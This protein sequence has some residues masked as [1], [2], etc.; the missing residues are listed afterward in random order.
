MPSAGD[1][2][3]KDPKILGGTPVFRGTRVPLQALFDSLEGGETLEEFLEGFP[4][5]SREMA[6][7]ALEEAQQ[8]LSSKA[9]MRIL[10]D[11]CVNQRLRNYLPGH[12][13]RSARYAGL[14]GL[15]NGELLKEAE[16]AKFDVLIT[17]DRGF[18][19]E[20]NLSG[21]KIAVII[22]HAKSIGLKDLLPLIGDCLSQLKSI[23]PGQVLRIG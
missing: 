16:A 11:E 3:V 21:R 1:I 13:C 4:G 10:L 19:Y 15:Q 20:Q 9:W 8:L 12:E 7:A 2:I 6:I 14:G 5:V 17:V 23:Q 22:F 18:Q